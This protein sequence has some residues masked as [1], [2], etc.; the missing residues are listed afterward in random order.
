MEELLIAGEPYIVDLFLSAV[1]NAVTANQTDGRNIAH[2]IQIKLAAIS[3]LAA[4]DELQKH[5]VNVLLTPAPRGAT[6]ER[7]KKSA[8]KVQT[9][10]L[11]IIRD[12]AAKEMK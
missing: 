11:D 1:R 8:E 4:H 3:L 5:G 10:V 7:R 9:Q 12:L 2:N 6:N